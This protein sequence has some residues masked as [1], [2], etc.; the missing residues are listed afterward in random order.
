MD[1]KLLS[2]MMQ[3]DV[4]DRLVQE[5]NDKAMESYHKQQEEKINFAQEAIK[6]RQQER[7]DAFDSWDV[8][9]EQLENWRSVLMMTYGAGVCFMDY[10]YIK[11]IAWRTK[12]LLTTKEEKDEVD[13]KQS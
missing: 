4:K 12:E 6:R 9:D 1:S 10:E 11:M 3:K 2:R 5:R 7:Q 13:P 8:S